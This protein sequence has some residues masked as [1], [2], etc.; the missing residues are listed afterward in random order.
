MESILREIIEGVSN[1]YGKSFFET[2]TLKMHQV[3]GADFTFIA[4]LDIKAHMSRTIAL[5]AGDE[6]V[7]NMEYSLENTPC[8]NVADNSVCMYPNKITRL[9]PHDQLLI[10]MGI[11]GYIGTPLHDSNGEVM[12][13]TV[14][15]YK[16]PIEN[17]EF[18]ETVFQVFS[19]RIAAEIDRMEY[20]QSLEKKVTQRTQHLEDTLT[21]LQLTQKQLIHQEKLASLGGVVAGVAHEIN[22]PLGLVKTSTSFQKDLLTQLVQKFE[23]QS[24]TL[25]AMKEFIDKSEEAS[26][27]IEL[28]L[29]RAIDLVN[30]FKFA[31]VDRIDSNLHEHKLNDFILHLITPLSAEFERNK[32]KV[33]CTIPKHI[34]IT[35]LGSD[36]S[37]VL[38]NLIMNSCVHAF[39]D[40]E[41]PEI[42][43]NA[44]E[45]ADNIIIEV[46]DNGIGID[47]SIRD[48]IYEPFVTTKRNQGSTGLGMNIVHN[49]VTCKLGGEISLLPS[50]QGATWQLI[51]PKALNDQAIFSQN[52]SQR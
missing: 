28:N 8:A 15:L 48:S 5:A 19:G 49:L 24:L 22:T 21:Q 18:I 10:D 17:P 16:T 51:L 6:I 14:A 1:N 36:L 35:T 37:Q 31:A 23:D 34:K 3:I 26:R 50:Q 20:A 2:I 12:G 30:N 44:K 11:E 25:S 45:R 52:V 42:A 32:I 46:K 27:V 33:N 29:E 39:P 38:N 7:D 4:R 41:Q 47:E 9:F 40:I 43:I 13:L